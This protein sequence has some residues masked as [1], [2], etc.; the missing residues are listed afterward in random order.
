MT[1]FKRF[2][3]VA[4]FIFTFSC[5]NTKVSK[6]IL[7]GSKNFSDA[8]I[9][10]IGKIFFPEII[11][12]GPV[13]AKLKDKRDYE[14]KIFNSDLFLRDSFQSDPL[15]LELYSKNIAFLYKKDLL[16]NRSNFKNIIVEIYNNKV[17]YKKFEFSENELIEY[18]KITTIQPIIIINRIF[19]PYK[20]FEESTA[21]EESK[22]LMTKN[23]KSIDKVTNKFDL[24]VLINVWMYYDPTDFPTRDLVFSVL[25]KNKLESIQAIKD[26]IKDKKEWEDDD[27]APF[28]ELKHLIEKLK[29]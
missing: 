25:E 1:L 23:I 12:H 21:S 13:D 5:Q 20:N 17:L 22:D 27:S 28:S 9:Q 10:E 29:K 2:F 24:E 4:I 11:K 19:E 16:K 14:I 6:E 3:F 26:R 7:L 8:G 15:N 18:S